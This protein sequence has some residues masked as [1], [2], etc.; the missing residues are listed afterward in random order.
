VLEGHGDDPPLSALALRR[1]GGPC[2]PYAVFAYRLLA[3][4]GFHGDPVE[5]LE[6]PGQ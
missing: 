2:S 6:S 1:G 3:R 4:A 5:L